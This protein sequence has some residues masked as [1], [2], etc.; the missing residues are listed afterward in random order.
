MGDKIGMGYIRKAWLTN[1][2]KLADTPDPFSDTLA[3]IIVLTVLV[4]Q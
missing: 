1:K 2:F 3:L 4:T